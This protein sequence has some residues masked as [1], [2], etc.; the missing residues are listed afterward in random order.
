[1]TRVPLTQPSTDLVEVTLDLILLIDQL[2]QVLRSRGSILELASLRLQWDDLRYE[3]RRESE[4]VKSEIDHVVTDAQAWLPGAAAAPRWEPRR[5]ASEHHP[6]SPQMHASSSDGSL[7]EHATIPKT[8]PLGS[9]QILRSPNRT[10]SPTKAPGSPTKPHNVPRSALHLSI[11]R[12]QLVGLQTRHRNLQY[13]LVKRSGAILDKMIDQAGRLKDLGGVEGPLQEEDRQRQH[14]IPDALIDLQEELEARATDIG[15]RVTWCSSFEQQC[16]KGHDHFSRSARAQR[17]GVDFMAE[18]K[19]ALAEPASSHKHATLAQMYAEALAVLPPPLDAASLPMP[20]HPAFPSKD[21]HNEAVF[22]ALSDARAD[23]EADL[24]IAGKVLAYYSSLLKSREAL[25]A[26]QARVQVLR[27]HLQRAIQQLEEG[28]DTAPRP[29]LTGVAMNGGDH[30]EWLRNVSTWADDGDMAVRAATDAREATVLAVMQ[31]RRALSSASMVVKPHLPAGGV[32]DDLGPLVDDDSEDL[33]ALG[34]RCAELAKRARSDA[35]AVPLILSIRET[36][37]EVSEGMGSLRS[38][39]VRSINLAAW[40]TCSPLSLPTTLKDDLAALEALTDEYSRDMERLRAMPSS[41]EAIPSLESTLEQSRQDMSEARHELDV[42]HRVSG[43]AET[44]RE[45]QSEAERLV[46]QLDTAAETLPEADA[47]ASDLQLADLR[48]QVSEWN[49]SIV[50][51]VA[52]VSGQERWSPTWPSEDSRT[53]NGP[54]TP[55]MTPVDR[56]DQSNT[57]PDLGA[58]DKRVRGEVNHHSVRVSSSLAR[59]VSVHDQIAFE[60]WASPVRSATES[61]DVAKRDLQTTLSGLMD[62][63]AKL[64]NGDQGARHDQDVESI[65]AGAEAIGK[66]AATVESLVANLNDVL[67]ADASAGV[68]M[69]KAADVFSSADV[70][71]EAALAQI[72]KAE[73]WQRQLEDIVAQSLLARSVTPVGQTAT[74]DIPRTPEQMAK[75]VKS[76]DAGLDALEIEALVHLSPAQLRATPKMRRLPSSSDAKKLSKAFTSIADTARSIARSQPN[77]PALKRLLDKVASQGSLVPDLEALSVVS[78]AAAV[79]DETFS[80]LLDTVDSGAGRE[81]TVVAEREAESAVEALELVAQPLLGDSRVALERRRVTNAWKELR[82]VAEDESIA[83]GSNAPSITGSSSSA[84]VST[85]LGEKPRKPRLFLNPTAKKASSLRTTVDFEPMKQGTPTPKPRVSSDTTKGRT[86]RHRPSLESTPFAPKTPGPRNSLPGRPAGRV[87]TPTVPVPFRL[88]RS[89][90]SYTNLAANLAEGSVAATPT[91]PRARMSDP[92]MGPPPSSSFSTL[93]PKPKPTPTPR[94]KNRLDAAVARVLEGLDVSAN[95]QER[96]NEQVRV[97]MV[98]AGRRSPD[99]WKDESGRYWIGTGPRARMCFCRILRS[100]TVM[101]RV[102][103]GWV[104]LSRYLLDHFEEIEM[105]SGAAE[106]DGEFNTAPVTITSASFKAT[107]SKG[108][109]L[110]RTRTGAST[111]SGSTTTTTSRRTPYTP[112]RA[113]LPAQFQFSPDN[114]TTP[115]PLRAAS[116]SPEK[117]PGPTGPGSPLIPLQFL[118]KA[119]ESPS[120]RDREREALRR[121]MRA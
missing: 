21:D 55:P 95:V 13:N 86:S 25:Q 37:A 7:G 110:T 108:P 117:A 27:E 33:V 14:A 69:R 36:N 8:P 47:D 115:L 111:E 5:R 83:S 97:P 16:R 107:A 24:D 79:C 20:S 102:G 50:S 78:D 9:N 66:H 68:D 114:A 61:L 72:T 62:E 26:Q 56:E 59:L 41:S 76:L 81:A 82:S 40:S 121:S 98:P 32:P 113:S 1:M 88:S 19:S 92:P 42:F 91:R 70:T 116:L 64:N 43:Q 18:I 120:V 85:R 84:T 31:Y 67:G 3:V 118:R 48:R 112:A 100:R 58:L 63:M 45:L 90:S 99:E 10:P 54:L 106:A 80:R 57:M 11:L 75:K 105:T 49:D 109:E 89:T 2:L 103:G 53:A 65:R 94:F 101:V 52:L 22:V 96:P 4:S 46:E 6:P 34:R 23:A 15:G 30:T 51:R 28:S 29:T 87:I 71:R 60:R 104:E 38:E 35:Q 12:S 39:V 73:K 93:R 74:D 44:V 77:S 17:A 119:S